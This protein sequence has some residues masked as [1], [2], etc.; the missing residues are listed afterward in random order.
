MGEHQPVPKFQ[1][2]SY[3][4]ETPEGKQSCFIPERLQQGL[5]SKVGPKAWQCFKKILKRRKQYFF[6]LLISGIN[7]DTFQYHLLHFLDKN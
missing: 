7:V 4:A 5:T 6:L 1:Y 3:T 2:S